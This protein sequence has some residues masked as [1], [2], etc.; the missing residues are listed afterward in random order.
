MPPLARAEEEPCPMLTDD[1]DADDRAVAAAA[2]AA[3]A[4]GRPAAATSTAAAPR[5]GRGGA[6]AAAAAGPL[7][8]RL[9]RAVNPYR[10]FLGGF[11]SLISASEPRSWSPARGAG[12]G[13]QAP[14]A[15]AAARAVNGRWRVWGSGLG[16]PAAAR[17]G[18]AAGFDVDE[19]LG[20][21]GEGEEEEEDDDEDC[22]GLVDEDTEGEDE[23]VGAAA[24]AA[25]RAFTLTWRR[26]LMPPG[27]RGLGPSADALALSGARQ[28]PGQ[29]GA[30]DAAAGAGSQQ[31]PLPALPPPQAC[32]FLRPGACFHG[33]QR[34]SQQLPTA[35]RP[36]DWAVSVVIEVGGRA[37]RA[38]SSGRG[39]PR[40]RSRRQQ[41]RGWRVGD[42]A[43]AGVRG[44]MPPCARTDPPGAAPAA[45][46]PLCRDRRAWT[47]RP[48]R[49]AARC[50][51]S[52]CPAPAARRL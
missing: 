52:M 9:A 49:C 15:A 30:A 47:R 37:Q 19:D 1:E 31:E 7:S 33:V 40:G 41:G 28:R 21:E 26:M 23:E 6:G 48:A 18:S 24:T 34:L 22:P 25:D 38:C 45:P 32:S 16:L 44:E 36:D 13:S 20:D 11:E 39:E 42:P 10:G 3:A 5:G 43:A 2:A 29:Q 46:S 27:A 12:A 8:D 51:R 14:S 17:A 50:K 4:V 35:R